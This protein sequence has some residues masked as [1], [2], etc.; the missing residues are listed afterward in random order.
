MRVPLPLGS[1][2]GQLGAGHAEELN[3]TTVTIIR[4]NN[5][6]AFQQKLEGEDLESANKCKLIFNFI[7]DAQ[8]G[9]NDKK[10]R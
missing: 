10:V 1:E 6:S 3:W 5:C 2:M 9:G 8:V 7:T 4:C